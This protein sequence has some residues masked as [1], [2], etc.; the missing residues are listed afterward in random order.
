MRVTIDVDSGTVTGAPAAASSPASASANGHAYTDDP[1][2][3]RDGGQPSAMLLAAVAAAGGYV[4][5]T[6]APGDVGPT[7]IPAT[8]AGRAPA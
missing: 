1:G 5:P 2:Q 3:A 7:A 6:D 4:G 8:D